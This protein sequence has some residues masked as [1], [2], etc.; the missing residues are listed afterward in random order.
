MLRNMARKRMRKLTWVAHRL[1]RKRQPPL[2]HQP[3][4]L[5]PA[6]LP[7]RQPVTQKHFV[8]LDQPQPVERPVPAAV[9]KPP[10][11]AELGTPDHPLVP[12][13]PPH[14]KQLWHRP[15]KKV[16]Q[17]LKQPKKRALRN[18]T[19]WKPL[20]KRHKMVKKPEKEWVPCCVVQ[21][22]RLA[23]RRLLDAADVVN[24]DYVVLGYPAAL[25]RK[26]VAHLHNLKDGEVRALLQPLQQVARPRHLAMLPLLKK[27][28]PPHAAKV[29]KK[30]RPAKLD[31][32]PPPQA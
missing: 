8:K 25:L 9:F 12:H 26:L 4:Q 6:I 10:H 21:A 11:H 16:Y 22:W 15:L 23:H 30:V 14:P 19:A 24:K 17:L 32:M 20:I 2:L 31:L 13:P 27:F 28:E 7:L 3:K 1:Y 29:V 5:Q 18:K